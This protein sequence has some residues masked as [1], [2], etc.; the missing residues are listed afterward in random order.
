MRQSVMCVMIVSRLSF[1][2]PVRHMFGDPWPGSITPFG[3]TPSAAVVQQVQA[4]LARRG[5]QFLLGERFFYS[6][7]YY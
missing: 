5:V 6:G 1:C 3:L 7:S 4:A 2:C